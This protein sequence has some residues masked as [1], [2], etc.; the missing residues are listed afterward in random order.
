MITKQEILNKVY[1]FMMKQNQK[2]IKPGNN[3][4]QLHYNDLRCNLGVLISIEEYKP[5][6]E[7]IGTDYDNALGNYFKSKGYDNDDIDWL[8]EL[9]L[10][11][12]DWVVEEW[13][14]AF[15]YFAYTNNL[16]LPQRELRLTFNGWV[17]LILILFS[18]SL[19]FI[20]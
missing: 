9:Q 19:F 14:T 15:N 10:I 1:P 7:N 16:T 2:C 5:E 20:V 8:W 18:L 3:D 11:H 6:F 17:L 12:D 4:Y 13:H